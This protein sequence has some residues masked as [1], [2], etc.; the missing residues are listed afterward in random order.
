MSD[1]DS[2]GGVPLI[3]PD[4]DGSKKRKRTD[5]ETRKA[6]KNRRN[7]KPNDIHEDELDEELGV[8]LAIAQMDGNL[9]VNYVARRT[10]KFEP[11]LSTVELDEL[12]LPCK[13]HIILTIGASC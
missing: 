1:S 12:Y 10:K 13:L 3:E 8:N 5:A 2:G 4:F 11:N 6:K 9:M 7:K